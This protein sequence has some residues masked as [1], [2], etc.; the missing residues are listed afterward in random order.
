MR[1][2][3]ILISSIAL[4]YNPVFAEIKTALDLK[5]I[6]IYAAKSVVLEHFNGKLNVKSNAQIVSGKCFFKIMIPRIV[7]SKWLLWF[8]KNKMEEFTPPFLTSR[9]SAPVTSI[10]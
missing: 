9:H 7:A 6:S 2:L 5:A 4:S 1:F 3:S 8:A 10:L